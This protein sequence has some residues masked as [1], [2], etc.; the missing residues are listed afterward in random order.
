M[1]DLHPHLTHVAP[2]LG[3]W[4]GRGHG[5]YPTI[6]S[7]DYEETVTFGHLGKPFLA[8]GQ[9]THAATPDEDGG[10]GGVPL[11][12]ETGYW[13]FPAPDRLEVV[14]CHP[15]GVTEIEE[16]T[17]TT[18][19]DGD[20]TIE[21]ASTNVVLSSTATSV[22]AIERTFRLHGDTLAYTVRMAAV[23]Q[24]LRHHLAATLRRA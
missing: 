9:R 3:T 8:Y 22:T 20:L 4:S 24:P 7:F 5:E 15:T 10:A 19:G 17:L 23:G 13:R 14:I 6:P 2:L 11:H 16:G 18:G 12:A 21:L 1:P